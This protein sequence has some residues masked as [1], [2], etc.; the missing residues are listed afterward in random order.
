M[1]GLLL[2]T[3]VAG[4]SA[5]TDDVAPQGNCG[6]NF[7]LTLIEQLKQK[8]RQTPAAEVIQYTYQ[9]RTTYLVTGGSPAALSYLFDNCGNV[10]C[11]AGG[12]AN[13]DGDGRCPDFATTATNPVL[14]W[15]DPR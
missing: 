4:C 2:L 7:S 12:G 14:I 1:A 13:N 5:T 8:P 3:G 15:R 10:I 11:A 9:G 6:G